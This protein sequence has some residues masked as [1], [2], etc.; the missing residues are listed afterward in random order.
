MMGPTF[1]DVLPA[2]FQASMDNLLAASEK[3]GVGHFVIP[4]IPG[5]ARG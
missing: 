4:S 1:D 2:F 5:L 3:G